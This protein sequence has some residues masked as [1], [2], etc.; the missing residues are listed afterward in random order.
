[1]TPITP[2]DKRSGWKGGRRVG[3]VARRSAGALGTL[4]LISATIFFL[5]NL[6]SPES[7]AGGIL[8]REA[9]KEQRSAF[10]EENNLDGAL[11]SRFF[12]WLGGV[13]QGDFGT[14]LASGRP[15]AG[16]LWEPFTMTLIL[17]LSAFAISVPVSVM[18][19]QWLARRAGGM[20]DGVISGLLGVIAAVPEFVVGIALI[21]VFGVWLPWFPIDSSGLA[22]GGPADKVKVF[23]LPVMTLVLSCTAYLGRVSRATVREALGAPHTRTAVLRGL[24]RR[25]VVWDHVVRASATN[26][27]SASMLTFLYLIGGVIVVENVFSFPGVG[28]LLVGAIQQG[29]VYVVLAVTLLLGVLVVITGVVSDAL[30]RHF[31]PRLRQEH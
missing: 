1:M 29:D 7:I 20:T 27:V 17:A 15:V 4:L 21:L 18:I 16:E 23:V 3:I 13:L 8:G 25:T 22:F 30:T 24:P 2:V 28:T 9:S 19:G 12:E 31:N 14:S 11:I 10:I 5:V 26:I 6:R